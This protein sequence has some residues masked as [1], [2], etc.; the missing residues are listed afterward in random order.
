[1]IDI[2]QLKGHIYDVVGALYEFTRSWAPVST[3]SAI[4][5]DF[6]FSSRNQASIMRKNSLFTLLTTVRP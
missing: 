1:M 6:R 3:S 4:K 5:K 2:H